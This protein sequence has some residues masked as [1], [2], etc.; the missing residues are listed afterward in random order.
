MTVQVEALS[1]DR[2][3]TRWQSIKLWLNAIEGAMDYDPHE[4]ANTMVRQLTQKVE[5][6]ETRVNEIES[7]DGDLDYNN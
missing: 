2:T 7:G 6:L 4:Y 1:E 5:Q 3:Q